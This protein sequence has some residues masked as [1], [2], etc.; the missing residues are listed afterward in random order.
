MSYLQKCISQ[1]RLSSVAAV[2]II[3]IL[4]SEDHFQCPIVKCR[5]LD[6]TD[7][8]SCNFNSKLL[9]LAM[10][11]SVTV[12]FA[13][14]SVALGRRLVEA[15]SDTTQYSSTATSGSTQQ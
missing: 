11:L 2:H 8:N 7:G 9:N 14:D 4:A 13:L 5:N 15:H 6:L 1:C 10:L 3:S 12:E